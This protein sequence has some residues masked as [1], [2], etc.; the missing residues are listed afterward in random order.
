[1]V[2]TDIVYSIIKIGTYILAFLYSVVAFK[3]VRER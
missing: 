1:M 2:G 3:V